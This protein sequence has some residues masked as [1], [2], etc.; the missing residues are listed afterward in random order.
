M[1]CPYMLRLNS[2]EEIMKR[3]TTAFF[4]L[5]LIGAVSLFADINQG[6]T[7]YKSYFR[8]A[9]GF[10]GNVMAKKHTYS[11]WQALFDAKELANE[12]QTLCPSAKPLKENDVAHLYE[13]LYHYASDSG[14]TALCY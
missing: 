1:I 11:E 10:S 8:T 12:L 9:C 4:A 3:Y 5:C 2:K 7:I 14:N 6:S 13:F